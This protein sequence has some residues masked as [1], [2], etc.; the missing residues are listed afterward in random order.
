MKIN[1]IFYYKS[2]K[3]FTLCA[4]EF[5]FTRANGTKIQLFSTDLVVQFSTQQ[6]II[7][8]LFHTISIYISSF[9]VLY[10]YIVDCFHTHNH[11]SWCVKCIII[12]WN[13]VWM[14][15]LC[16]VDAYTHS[17]TLTHKLT[18]ITKDY[19]NCTVLCLVFVCHF[20][21]ILSSFMQ[22]ILYKGKYNG[23]RFELDLREVCIAQYLFQRW[24]TY[25][26]L[27]FI[28]LLWLLNQPIF[29][30]QQ[31]EHACKM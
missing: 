7:H 3:C 30:I 16:H 26:N 11:M 9:I 13:A 31:R 18:Y 21:K 15:P 20:N 8:F 14:L 25:I 6:K 4:H 1:S 27:Q 2:K 29:C 19:M 23:K 12:G 22:D 5:Y 17:Q 10:L 28:K 24:G